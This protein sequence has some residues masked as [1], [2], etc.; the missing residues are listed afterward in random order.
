MRNPI[1]GLMALVLTITPLIAVAVPPLDEENVQP[2]EGA[3]ELTAEQLVAAV[4]NNN[5]GLRGLAAAAEAAD[6][7]IAPPGGHAVSRSGWN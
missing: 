6:Y 4:L 2:L 5:A 3:K 1:G 7:R